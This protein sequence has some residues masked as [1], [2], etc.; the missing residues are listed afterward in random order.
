[1][2][3]VYI[4]SFIMINLV[5]LELGPGQDMDRRKYGRTK[6]P[7]KLC[8]PIGEHKQQRKA[9]KWQIKTFLSKAHYCRARIIK[10][11]CVSQTHFILTNLTFDLHVGKQL[12]SY[13]W[14]VSVRNFVLIDVNI[15]A[16]F[17]FWNSSIHGEVRTRTN[18]IWPI[19]AIDL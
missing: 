3:S 14:D 9:L 1:M 18:I 10:I 5:V 7:L 17:F 11:Q 19:L 15:C 6:R 4:L 12:L 8:S 13:K 2:R 16:N